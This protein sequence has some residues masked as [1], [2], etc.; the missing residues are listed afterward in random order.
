M[1]NDQNISPNTKKLEKDLKFFNDESLDNDNAD[2][3]NIGD[4]EDEHLFYSSKKK[5][6]IIIC[7]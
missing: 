7:P 3:D 1:S 5:N 4:D 6:K 2:D